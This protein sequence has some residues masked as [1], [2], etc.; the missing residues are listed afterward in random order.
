MPRRKP[1]VGLNAKKESDLKEKDAKNKSKVAP[2]RKGK[3]EKRERTEIGIV[4]KVCSE[5]A[6]ARPQ[7]VY[8]RRRLML[9]SHISHVKVLRFLFPEAME[10]VEVG[11][12]AQQAVDLLGLSQFELKMLKRQFEDIDVDGSGDID[13]DE[14][15]D[16]IDEPGTP[17]SYAL[18]SLIDLDG[19]GTIDY[20][21]YIQFLATW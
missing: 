9:N 5:T 17:Y 3:R 12:L 16:F 15:F 19:S 11:P 18:F 20:D 2:V 10:E 1:A 14:F 7:E 13:Y 4:T 21:E 8:V 6:R